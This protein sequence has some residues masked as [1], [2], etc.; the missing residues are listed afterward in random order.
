M[1]C[2]F[3]G[4]HIHFA[5]D[6]TQRREGFLF[7]YFLVNCLQGGKIMENKLKIKKQSHLSQ[8]NPRGK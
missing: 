8:K 6:E 3:R 2:A 1:F 7:D 4:Q 5:G